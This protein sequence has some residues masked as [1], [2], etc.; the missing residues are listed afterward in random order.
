MGGMQP[1]GNTAGLRRAR[2]F[3][4]A[5]VFA[6][7]S[8][9]WLYLWLEAA[10]MAAMPMDTMAMPGPAAARPWNLVSLAMTF[11]M[12]SVMMVGMMLPSAAPAITLYG[13][14]VRKG[15]ESGRGLPSA[16]IF[17]AGYIAVWTAFSLAATLLQAGL[18]TGRLLTPMM[19]SASLPLSSSLLIVAGIYQWLP[20]KDTCL[21][22]CRAP[23][24]FFMFRWKPGARGAFRMGAEHGVF[25][26]GC[27]WALMLL[28]FAV[29]VM[30][31]LWVALITGFVLIEKL[32]PAGRTI[33]RVAGLGLIVAG[34]FRI[35]V[36]G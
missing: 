5:S 23:L 2:W 6:L 16:W 15:H 29:G 9:A 20:L 28:L 30:N 26:V 31:L 21:E 34:A 27:C 35:V 22:K 36:I 33:G 1:S 14:M 11:L 8:V 19:E 24:S 17:V 13:T 12:W 4:L 3:T 7:A 18:T 10:R 25:C 32:L